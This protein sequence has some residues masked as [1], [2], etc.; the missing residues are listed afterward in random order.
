MGGIDGT[1]S[2]RQKVSHPVY[3]LLARVL[4][5]AVVLSVLASANQAFADPGTPTPNGANISEV[6]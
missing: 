6:T 5:L 4:T 2:G 1:N 3:R